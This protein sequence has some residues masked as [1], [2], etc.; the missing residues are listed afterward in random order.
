VYDLTS[1]IVEFLFEDI[2]RT[3]KQEFLRNFDHENIQ[4]FKSLNGETSFLNVYYSKHE[5]L[6]GIKSTL[7][8]KCLHV[9]R[10]VDWIVDFFVKAPNRFLTSKV[11]LY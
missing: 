10:L 2:F 8:C 7:R 1:E 6:L 3:Y 11:C 4:K 9:A 5:C